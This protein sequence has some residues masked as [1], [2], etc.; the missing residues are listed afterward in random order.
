MGREPT[1]GHNFQRVTR[2]NCIVVEVLK[3]LENA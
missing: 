1:T 2:L 3:S